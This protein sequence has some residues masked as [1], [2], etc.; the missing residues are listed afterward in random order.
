MQTFEETQP[1]RQHLSRL[2]H[3][4]ARIALVPTMGNLHSGHFRLIELARRHADVVVVSVFVN[5]TQFGPGEDFE[6]YPR[7][8]D[9]D[10]HGLRERGCDI[11]FAPSAAHM[12]P[13]PDEPPVLLGMPGL[14]DVLEGAHRPGHFQGVATVVAKLLNRVQPDCAIF[15]EKDYQQL[16]VLRRLVRALDF[17]VEIIGAPTQRAADGLALSSRNQYLN[18][19]QRPRAAL[20]Y[21][22]LQW[23]HAEVADTERP[24]DAIA[25]DATQRLIEAGFQPDYVALR[26][27]ESLAAPAP[28]QRRGLVALVAA[29]LGE[30]RLLDSLPIGV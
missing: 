28:G 18:G 23:L 30:T 1:L 5:P 21:Q 16:L 10:A 19:E 12:Y 26:D 11:L 4:G 22:T 17:Q 7:T 13:Y 24:L 27:A 6:R 3:K 8:L 2:R 25:R 14:D 29:R 15:G 20:V 9:A